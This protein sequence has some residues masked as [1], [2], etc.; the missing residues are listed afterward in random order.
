MLIFHA[1]KARTQAQVRELQPWGFNL[2]HMTNESLIGGVR[3]RILRRV[4][5]I[6]R[7]VCSAGGKQSKDLTKREMP[8]D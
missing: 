8:R 6:I 7:D 2:P 4:L 1:P 3:R 5:L